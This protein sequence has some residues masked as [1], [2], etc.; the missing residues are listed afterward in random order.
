MLPGYTFDFDVEKGRTRTHMRGDGSKQFIKQN[1]LTGVEMVYFPLIEVQRTSV[2]YVGDGNYIRPIWYPIIVQ[3]C[4]LNG[5]EDN[6]L[7]DIVPPTGIF[8]GVLFVIQLTNT[9]LV[10]IIWYVFKLLIVF[11]PM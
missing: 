6:Y 4:N 3:R 2:L 7:L 8:I 1:G 9:N 5:N 11:F 10:N